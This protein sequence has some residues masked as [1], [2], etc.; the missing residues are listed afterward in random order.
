MKNF[1][2]A[3]RPGTGTQA[4]PI[5]NHRLNFNTSAEQRER[6]LNHL[7]TVGPLSTLKARLELDI[8][9]PAGRVQEL[10]Q[11]GHEILTSWVIVHTRNNQPH[12]IAQYVL[13]KLAPGEGVTNGTD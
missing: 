6:L 9:H 10:R 3:S 12:K 5:K 11:Q 1:Q 8:F 4:L 2:D 7:T 13:L